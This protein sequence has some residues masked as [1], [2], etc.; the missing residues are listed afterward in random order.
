MGK[1]DGILIVSDLDGTLLNDAHQIPQANQD[2]IAYFERDG[3]AM[4]LLPSSRCCL[5]AIF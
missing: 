1:F 5:L 2:A 4:F 3:C